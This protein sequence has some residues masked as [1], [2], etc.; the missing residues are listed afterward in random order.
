[1][2]IET[3]AKEFHASARKIIT[4]QNDMID[5]LGFGNYFD[6]DI[7]EISAMKKIKDL[8]KNEK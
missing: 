8:I 4:N 1:L 3:G 5:K 6:C 7:N 2:I